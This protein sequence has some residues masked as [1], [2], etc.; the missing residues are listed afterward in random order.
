MC[1]TTFELYH[2]FANLLSLIA[3]H[4]LRVIWLM[5]SFFS[6]VQTLLLNEVMGDVMVMDRFQHSAGAFC[7]YFEHSA[8]AF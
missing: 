1:N 2:Y 5:C 4:E 8:T 3:L 7:K 6:V